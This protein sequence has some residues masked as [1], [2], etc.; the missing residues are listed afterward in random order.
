VF[1]R[2]ASKAIRWKDIMRTVEKCKKWV[3]ISMVQGHHCFN[4]ANRNG[5]P[6]RAQPS[7]ACANF[8]PSNTASTG[9]A[10]GSVS[11][12]LSASKNQP[13]TEAGSPALR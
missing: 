9:I 5:F 7:R 12:A 8:E 11:Q 3:E 4:C 10:A 13:V 6:Y 1:N 2:A